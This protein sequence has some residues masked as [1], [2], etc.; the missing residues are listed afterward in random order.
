[1]PYAVAYAPLGQICCITVKIIYHH[2][3]VNTVNDNLILPM[4]LFVTLWANCCITVK[5][6][7]RR[8]SVNT[9]IDDL[10]WHQE[11]LKGL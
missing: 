9:V 1:M 3:S 5:I 7:Y 11:T 10:F 6:I 8:Q 2:E 4:L